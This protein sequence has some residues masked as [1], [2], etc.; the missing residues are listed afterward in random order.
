MSSKKERENN[1]EEDDKPRRKRKKLDPY[2][3]SK[4]RDLDRKPKDDDSDGSHDYR[5]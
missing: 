1:E 2:N 4:V 5:Y 3:R